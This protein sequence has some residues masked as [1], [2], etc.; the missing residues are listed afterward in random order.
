ML[1]RVHH[2]GLVVQRLENGLAFWQDTLGLLSASRRRSAI[3]ACAPRFSRSGGARSRLLEPI[4][5]AGGVA[6]FLE[7]R[8]EG[9]RHVCFETPDVGGPRP[10]G[11]GLPLIDE[12]RARACSPA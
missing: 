6:K 7:L 4:D 8:G 3:R 5:P 9:L 2:V 11:Q 10:R 1:T 12:A